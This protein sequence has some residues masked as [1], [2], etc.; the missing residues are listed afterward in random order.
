M[1]I[2]SRVVNNIAIKYRF[3]I[4]RLD[5]ML[6]ELCG[7]KLFSNV[8]LR[9]GYHHIRMREGDEWVTTFK[10]KHGLHEWLVMLFGLTNAPST[11]MRLMNEVLRP[12]LGRLIMVY[13]DDILV[14]SKDEESHL[15]HL[16]ELVGRSYLG[17]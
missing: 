10:I 3:P 17:R 7:A 6:N 2:D 4:P 15:K 14:Y 8:D 1:C 11:F 9:R 12:F 5:N 16:R 13:L